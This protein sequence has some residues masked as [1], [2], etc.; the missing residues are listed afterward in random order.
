MDCEHGVIVAGSV[1]ECPSPPS[2]QLV[3]ERV[4]ARV[5]DGVAREAP[6]EVVETIDGLGARVLDGRCLCPASLVADGV[7]ERLAG[8]GF[9]ADD[10]RVAACRGGAKNDVVIADVAP[11]RVE[12]GFL[13]HGRADGGQLGELGCG[14]KGGE[15]IKGSGPRLGEGGCAGAGLLVLGVDAVNPVA[16]AGERVLLLSPVE[17]HPGATPYPGIGRSLASG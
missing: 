17:P 11:V 9:D 7:A 2:Q 14:P 5:I 12:R 13:F 6:E 3:F 1:G 16:V 10:H 15:E 4:E 8:F